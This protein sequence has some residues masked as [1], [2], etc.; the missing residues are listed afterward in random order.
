MKF[1]NYDDLKVGDFVT[2]FK[3]LSLTSGGDNLFGNNTQVITK[4][5]RSY[6]GDVLEVK[7]LECPY[8]VLKNHNNRYL[9]ENHRITLDIREYTLIKLSKEYVKE[10][11]LDRE[12]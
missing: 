1:T 2:I 8:V 12:R 9:G 3:G 10:K 6:K 5:D 4:E 7:V 11:L